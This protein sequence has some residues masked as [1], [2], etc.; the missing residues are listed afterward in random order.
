MI[1]LCLAFIVTTIPNHG[2]E[3]HEQ[4]HTSCSSMTLAQALPKIFAC[5]RQSAEVCEVIT[6]DETITLEWK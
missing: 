1:T 6:R 2:S 3:F 5:S 4:I